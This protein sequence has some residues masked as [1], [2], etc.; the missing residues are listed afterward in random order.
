ME[1][2]IKEKIKTLKPYVVQE[3]DCTI[4]LDANENSENLFRSCFND[5]VK[6]VSEG[7]INRYPDPSSTLL[8][9][10]V[11][12][13][14]GEGVDRDNIICGNGSDELI[15]CII[16]TFV[17]E[18]DTVVTHSPTFSM[19][20]ISNQIL[21]GKFIEVP[22]NEKFEVN[23]DEI[24]NV[25]NEN[26]AKLIILC[27]P[28]NPTGTII[29]RED[30]EKVI[31][32][33]N[34]VVIVD[35][36][37]YEFLGESLVDI[38]KENKRVIVL[39]TL[40]KGFALAGARCGYLVASL[41]TVN[42]ILKVKP[43]YNLNTLTQYAGECILDNYE[44]VSKS[45]E[46]I[47]SQRDAMLPK[48]REVKGLTVYDTGAN[49]ILV[50]T[51]KCSEVIKKFEEEKI[52]VRGFSEGALENCIRFSIGFENENN[53]VIEIISEVLE[54]ENCKA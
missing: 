35:E 18:S 50:K 7:T 15:S 24:I 39:R 10:K 44:K 1:N 34:A 8:R 16:S 17:G 12:N 29:K 13:Y 43:P 36:A 52:L 47:K 45:I 28:N 46:R 22:S 20:K 40:S 6:K 54:N 4:K 49:F 32:S 38:A 53:K 2:Y 9:E 25:S 21:G 41:D 26:N 33:T 37:Y 42:S 5:F 30:I 23:I 14:V 51:D 27:N 3:N 19:Y 11:A 48:L 31:N